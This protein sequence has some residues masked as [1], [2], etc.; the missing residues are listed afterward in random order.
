M[1]LASVVFG[2]FRGDLE[3]SFGDELCRLAEEGLRCLLDDFFR[4][5]VNESDRLAAEARV[6]LVWGR[7]TG[8]FA[9]LHPLLGAGR[10]TAARP[11]RP[12]LGA[13]A[14]R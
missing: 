2:D 3:V 7:L 11:G 5:A 14:L 4:T 6:G 8:R 13:G 12:G 10:A 9:A 1:V